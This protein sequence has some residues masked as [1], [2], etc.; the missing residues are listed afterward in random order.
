MGNSFGCLGYEKS[1][2]GILMGK[3]V[4]FAQTLSR[5]L[6]NLP[7]E[8][9]R[10]EKLISEGKVLVGSVDAGL[11]RHGAVTNYTPVK[12]YKF[13]DAA[14]EE[15]QEVLMEVAAAYDFSEGD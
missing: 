12:A 15:W 3:R 13:T 10:L 5:G 1:Q 8:K 2:R 11:S 7:W 6:H 14:E 4:V 9:G